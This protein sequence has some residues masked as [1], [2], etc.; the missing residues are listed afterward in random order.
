MEDGER[1]RVPFAQERDAAVRAAG[2]RRPD[3]PLLF[4]HP[5]LCR[6]RCAPACDHPSAVHTLFGS[7]KSLAVLHKKKFALPQPPFGEVQLQATML[8]GANSEC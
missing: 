1:G 6:P 8:E 7:T 2:L 5:L 3:H 4:H